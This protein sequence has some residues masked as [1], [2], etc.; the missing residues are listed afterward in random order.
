M[1]LSCL[2]SHPGKKIYTSSPEVIYTVGMH[3]WLQFLQYTTKIKHNSLYLCYNSS[4]ALGG[5]GANQVLI[6]VFFGHGTSHS[7]RIYVH[8]IIVL[9]TL[10]QL[11]QCSCTTSKIFQDTWFPKLSSIAV[12]SYS[13]CNTTTT[14]LYTEEVLKKML[15]ILTQHTFIY[16]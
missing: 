11:C 15:L 9:N 16:Y 12:I 10:T 7:Y 1:F 8:D 6:F 14:W 5:N 3:A 4:C 13:Y 2:N